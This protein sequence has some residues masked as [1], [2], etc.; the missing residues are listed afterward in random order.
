MLTLHAVIWEE[1]GVYVVKEVF[2][3]VTTQGETIEEALENLKEAVE[4]YLEEFPELKEE[5][6]KIKLIGDFNVQIAKALG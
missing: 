1:E 6:R 2:T 4:L 3:G 5:L